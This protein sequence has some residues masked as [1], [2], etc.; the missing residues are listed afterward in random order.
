MHN[1]ASRGFPSLPFLL[2]NHLLLVKRLCLVVER[3]ALLDRGETLDVG[4]FLAAATATIHGLFAILAARFL[5]TI[6]PLL[7]FKR[8]PLARPEPVLAVLP[9]KTWRFARRAETFF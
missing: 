2:R 4:A 5:D 1:H 6:L 3:R 7:F 9:A 8:S